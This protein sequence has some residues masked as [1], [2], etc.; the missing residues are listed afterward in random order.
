MNSI[1]NK[2]IKRQYHTYFDW[3]QT[4][5]INH[6]LGLFGRDFKNIIAK[7]IKDNSDL[8]RQ[9]QA[10]LEIGLERNKMVHQNFLD[11]NLEKTFDEIRE[12]HEQATSF[13]EYM[14]NVFSE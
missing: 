14:E 9:V 5:N 13:I 12:L 10:F 3:N 6:F 7:E 1:R 2:A 8:A 11:Y 4:N